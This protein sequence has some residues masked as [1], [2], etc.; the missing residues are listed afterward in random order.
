MGLVG[1]STSSKDVPPKADHRDMTAQIST[2]QVLQSVHAF[3]G[4]TPVAVMLA[5]NVFMCC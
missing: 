3:L 2:S 1:R 5:T 4:S